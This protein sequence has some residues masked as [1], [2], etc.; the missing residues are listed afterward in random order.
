MTTMLHSWTTEFN[1]IKRKVFSL[2]FGLETWNYRNSCLNYKYGLCIIF[3][4][5]CFSVMYLS[6][7]YFCACALG[8]THADFE[9]F[10]LEHA[11]HHFERF[12]IEHERIYAHGYEKKI[13]F[14]VFKDNLEKANELN[15]KSGRAMFG[16]VG[17]LIKKKRWLTNCWMIKNIFNWG[18]QQNL[19]CIIKT[20]CFTV[21][22]ISSWI[23]TDISLSGITPFSDLTTEEFV[24]D[25]TGLQTTLG[26]ENLCKVFP[27]LPNKYQ[28]EVASSFD[29]R[30][31]HAVTPVKF[32]GSCGSCY[33]FSAIGEENE[34]A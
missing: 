31:R 9:P 6:L 34:I 22:M 1:E 18:I 25:Y 27:L 4:C 20:P 32:Q 30:D 16:M 17:N 29:W 12:I 28:G 24:R 15:Q 23:K 2:Q 26:D 19:Q 7:V 33:A 21:S 13:R 3:S 14:Q 10:K 8:L 11:E 5:S